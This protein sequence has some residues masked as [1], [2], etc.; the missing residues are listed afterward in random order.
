MTLFPIP[1]FV[2]PV[3][4]SEGPGSLTGVRDGFTAVAACMNSHILSQKWQKMLVKLLVP[5]N[6]V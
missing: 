1:C 6:L 5:V 3:Y 4:L 2:F